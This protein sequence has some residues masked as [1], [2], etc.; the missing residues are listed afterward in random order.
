MHPWF[1]FCYRSSTIYV[2]YYFS[3]ILLTLTDSISPMLTWIINICQELP[4]E[5]IYLTIIF[6]SC[7]YIIQLIA[8]LIY[9]ELIICNF[10]N[11]NEYT[12]KYL[13]E[14]E[15]KEL[16]PLR[17]TENKFSHFDEKLNDTQKETDSS[18]ISEADDNK[19][20]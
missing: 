14:R 4:K 17:E 16:V 10:C 13:Q 5:N 20:D 6:N 8:A 7:G 19:S 12:K 3:P 9:N 1:V 11:L 15:N 18:F 2:I